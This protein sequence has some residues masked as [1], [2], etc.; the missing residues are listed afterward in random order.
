MSVGLYIPCKVPTSAEST[1]T[2]SAD[3]SLLSAPAI[4]SRLS[5]STQSALCPALKAVGI[6]STSTGVKA[7]PMN[8]L[9]EQEECRR[10]RLTEMGKG[11]AVTQH[12][13][14]PRLLRHQCVYDSSLN[15]EEAE[16][17]SDENKGVLPRLS[18]AARD[19]AAIPSW[20]R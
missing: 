6:S 3:S 20:N 5:N 13:K 4:P 11:E 18:F 2:V 19:A 1:R 15:K 12:F 17:V 8:V 9:Q 14:H 7:A 10:G 16:A